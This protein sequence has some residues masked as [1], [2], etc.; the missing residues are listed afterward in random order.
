MKTISTFIIFLFF[1]IITVFAQVDRSQYPEPAPA[2]IINIGNAESF[3]LPN[4]LKVFVV[5]NHKLPRVT[6]SLVLDR[7]PILEAEKAGYIGLVG[8]LMMAGTKS[9]SKD[10]LDES[11]D[12]IGARIQVSSTSASATSLKK[13]QETLLKLF[14]DVLFNPS[15]PAEELDKLKMQRISALAADKD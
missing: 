12:H 6:F 10:Q 4:G 11:I 15:F 1:S 8:Q 3:T 13:H 7:D 14:S 9:L 2:P 5:E